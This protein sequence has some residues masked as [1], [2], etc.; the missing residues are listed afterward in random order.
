MLDHGI[1]K[2]IC[3]LH[4]GTDFVDRKESEVLF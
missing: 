2:A 1:D 3:N 4:F